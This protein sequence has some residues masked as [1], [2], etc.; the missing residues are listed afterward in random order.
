MLQKCQLSIV[1]SV[2]INPQKGKLQD[3]KHTSLPG[4]YL[5]SC[6]TVQDATT[7]TES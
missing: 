3:E 5:L 6:H 7:V 2:I 1:V 4:R